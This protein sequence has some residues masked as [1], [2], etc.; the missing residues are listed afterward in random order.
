MP[1]TM[2]VGARRLDDETFPLHEYSPGQSTAPFTSDLERFAAHEQ[3][4]V[5]DLRRWAHLRFSVELPADRTAVFGVSAS[6][7]LALAVGLRHPHIYGSVFA[8]AGYNPI[9]PTDRQLA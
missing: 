6:A 7:E 2:V 8:A 9:N 3:F 5:D 1:P 4:L